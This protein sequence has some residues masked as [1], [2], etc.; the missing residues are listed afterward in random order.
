MTYEKLKANLSSFETGGATPVPK[1]MDS[2]RRQESEEKEELHLGVMKT[3]DNK[4]IDSKEYTKQM[5][6]HKSYQLMIEDEM[7]VKLEGQEKKSKSTTNN[8]MK[9]KKKKKPRGQMVEIRF[10][11]GHEQSQK[12]VLPFEHVTFLEK[13]TEINYASHSKNM[14]KVGK[15]CFYCHDSKTTFWAYP[16][17][18][19]K[20]VTCQHWCECAQKVITRTVGIRSKK[21]DA[22]H[23]GPCVTAVANARPPIPKMQ[24]AKLFSIDDLEEGKEDKKD[25]DDNQFTQVLGKKRSFNKME[26]I[27]GGKLKSREENWNRILSNKND[28]DNETSEVPLLEESRSIHPQYKAFGESDTEKMEEENEKSTA[29]NEMLSDYQSS[30][31]K[32][33]KISHPNENLE[34]HVL[35][36]KAEEML[37]NRCFDK[38]CAIYHEY[39]EKWSYYEIKDNLETKEYLFQAML[40]HIFSLIG[41]E[42]FEVALEKCSTFLQKAT[43]REHLDEALRLKGIILEKLNKI[44]EA[45]AIYRK[46]AFGTV[47]PCRQPL[48]ECIMDTKPSS[49]TTNHNHYENH[50]QPLERNISIIT[51]KPE[52]I[53]T[54]TNH[55]LVITQGELPP[56]TPMPRLLSL[57]L[58][59]I[60]QVEEPKLQHN[61]SEVNCTGI[62]TNGY[63]IIYQD[64]QTFLE[65]QLSTLINHSNQNGVPVTIPT[66]VFFPYPVNLDSLLLHCK[67]LNEFLGLLGLND[68]LGQLMEQQDMILEDIGNV[69]LDTHL[70]V[71]PAALNGVQ[72]QLFDEYKQIPLV[73]AEFTNGLKKNIQ[74]NLFNI[75]D[76]PTFANIC[77]VERYANALQEMGHDFEWLKN[78][79]KLIFSSHS[80]AYYEEIELLARKLSGGLYGP[81]CRLF[82]GLCFYG[83]LLSK[84]ELSFSEAVQTKQSESMLSLTSSLSEVSEMNG[85]VWSTSQSSTRSHLETLADLVDNPKPLERINSLSSN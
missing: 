51:I 67:T 80:N 45:Y 15:C 32:R 12:I 62:N 38:A 22:G 2:L 57:A 42:S 33:Q 77:K 25:M 66:K 79:L 52:T 55:S 54:N 35:L 28:Y 71:S 44:S 37:R 36:K 30:P 64:P 85:L 20:R 78:E 10:S 48:L 41:N 8:C 9:K 74:T 56:L 59:D 23:S 31:S 72:K 58:D 63:N 50:D 34:C 17:K 5:E 24:E 14:Y 39:F 70:K 40:N 27:S 75:T 82:L 11:D 6:G 3:M 81:K 7:D 73:V 46:I 65:A 49:Y 68:A 84:S 18:S 19:T 4:K 76:F 83:D 29:M 21:C 47:M 53:D 26:D 60:N 1:K 61:T 69:N 43:K 13:E 16:L